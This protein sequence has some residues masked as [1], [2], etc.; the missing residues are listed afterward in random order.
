MLIPSSC[1]SCV[2][3]CPFLLAPFGVRSIK[4][5][6]RIQITEH[7]G[8]F[9][10]NS[11]MRTCTP[12]FAQ[13][14][15]LIDQPR[16]GNVF[17]TGVL[18]I[19]IMVLVLCCDCFSETGEAAANLALIKEEGESWHMSEQLVAAFEPCLLSKKK[20]DAPTKVP[21]WP[22][23]VSDNLLSALSCAILPSMH[24]PTAESSTS[25]EGAARDQGTGNGQNGV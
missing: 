5:R 16:P 14:V 8:C 9:L 13:V 6:A 4:V 11:C 17:L 7:A 20:K 2:H 21:N 18:L 15:H 1:L 23:M 12:S 22:T 25:F 3:L 19:F 10:F 24:L